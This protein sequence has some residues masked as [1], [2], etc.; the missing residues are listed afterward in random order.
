MNNDPLVSII[1]PVYNTQKKYLLECLESIK[2]Q[3][4]RNTEVIIVDDGSDEDTVKLADYFVASNSKESEEQSWKIIRQKNK[5]LSAARNTGYKVATGKYIQF[6]DS[7]DYFDSR[8]ISSAVARAEDTGA[9]IVVENF[10]INDYD[11]GITESVLA[12]SNF[13]KSDT[14]TLKNIQ[15]NKFGAIPYNVW[16]KL[17]RKD[18]LDKSKI[19]HDESLFRAEDVLFSYTAL[20]VAKKISLLPDAYIT[21][22][23]NLPNSNTA[24]NDKYPTVSV[25][26]WKKLYNVLKSNNL[27]KSYGKD[28]EEAMLGSIYWHLNRLHTTEGKKEL[29]IH[30]RDFLGEINSTI[31]NDCSLAIVGTSVN[32]GFLQ[33]IEDRDKQ[34]KLQ[35]DRISDLGSALLQTTTERDQL[36]KPGVKHASRNL[37]GAVKRKLQ[38]SIYGKVKKGK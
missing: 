12:V 29:A 31:I 4:Y 30:A 16:S 28:F 26:S 14:F 36:R 22:R 37:A 32:P 35:D 9:E 10:A 27:Q 33:F 25:E 18:F 5:G 3:D 19:L 20:T 1:V 17:F 6:L 13:P 38:Y 8:L 7:D 2:H 24:T 11:A 23:E 15:G 21:Y 34:I